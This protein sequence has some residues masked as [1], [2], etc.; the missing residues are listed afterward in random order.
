MLLSILF[1]NNFF[2][3]GIGI[4]A[5][6]RIPNVVY[7]YQIQISNFVQENSQFWKFQC[8]H[9]KNF[10]Q[11]G[12]KNT[13]RAENKPWQTVSNSLFSLFRYI[14]PWYEEVLFI[15][16]LFYS[17]LIIVFRGNFCPDAM[18]RVRSVKIETYFISSKSLQGV[19]KCNFSN[20]F[21]FLFC[22][23]MWGKKTS[24][25]IFSKRERN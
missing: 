2:L 7:W 9:I 18:F 21:F 4:V 14:H 10:E 22:S 17:I 16:A 8:F 12:K 24:I 23:I 6:S 25:Q 1:W 19:S 3:L 15:K 20:G 5:E 13:E 11:K